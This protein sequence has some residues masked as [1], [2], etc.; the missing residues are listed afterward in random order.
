MQEKLLA[1]L[2]VIRRCVD[3]QCTACSVKKEGMCLV[4]RKGFNFGLSQGLSKL[5]WTLISYAL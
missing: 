4:I 2:K 5:V 1:A 3:G